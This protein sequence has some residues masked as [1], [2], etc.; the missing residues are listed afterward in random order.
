MKRGN[1]LLKSLILSF[2]LSSSVY[3]NTDYDIN[4]KYNDVKYQLDCAR[5]EINKLQEENYHLKEDKSS[6]KNFNENMLKSNYE[7]KN[8]QTSLKADYE[9]LV[10]Q[11]EDL[12]KKLLTA[13]DALKNI[14]RQKALLENSTNI[15]DSQ[16]ADLQDRLLK[17]ENDLNNIKKQATDLSSLIQAKD[18][19]IAE[20]SKTYKQKDAEINMLKNKLADNEKNI[21]NVSEVTVQKNSPEDE[22]ALK[23]VKLMK[24]DEQSK[25]LYYFNMAKAYQQDKSIEKAIENYKLAIKENPDLGA[26]YSQLGIIYA[27]KGDYRNSIDIFNKYLS[28]NLTKNPEERELI[29]NFVNKMKV[30]IK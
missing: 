10:S 4:E 13:Q 19:Q 16:R 8:E 17:A 7:M 14:Q 18:N 30:L 26:A 6:L 27:E 15:K 5:E 22:A 9:K 1:F 23:A 21:K 2:L 20:F 29:R 25:A 12:Q 24:E 11:K 3:A 28:L